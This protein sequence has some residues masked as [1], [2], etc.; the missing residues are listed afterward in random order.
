[1]D[2]AFRFGTGLILGPIMSMVLLLPVLI[3]VVARFRDNRE[4]TSDTQLGIKVVLSWFQIIS[5]Q[6]LMVAGVVLVYS[7]LEGEL[8]EVRLSSG[9]AVP[10]VVIAVLLHFALQQTNSES[11]PSVKNM[12]KGVGLVFTGAVAFASLVIGGVMLFQKGSSSGQGT[13]VAS[14][15]LIYGIAALVQG[16][17]FL[18]EMT[19]PAQDA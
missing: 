17:H 6:V 13:T 12:V 3:Y 1:M 16:M 18:R 15:V 8:G 9:L 2:S 11:R 4:D 19:A 7:V 5:Y 14:V 10:S